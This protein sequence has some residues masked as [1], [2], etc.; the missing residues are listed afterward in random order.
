MI[1][2]DICRYIA[3]I[4]AGYGD[5]TRRAQVIS[6]LVEGNSINAT[7]RM[8]GVGKHTILRLLEDAGQ[9]CAA[10]HD[11]YVRGVRSR[12]VQCD[13]VWSFVGPR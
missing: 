10:F 5:E 3:I 9:A 13:E 8:L 4:K 6:A 1:V 7:C 12:R 11:E 2:L